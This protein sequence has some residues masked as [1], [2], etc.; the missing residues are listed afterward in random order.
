MLRMAFLT[1]ELLACFLLQFPSVLG[2]QCQKLSIYYNLWG[3]FFKKTVGF[4]HM[5]TRKNLFTLRETIFCLKECR[6][7]ST[8]EVL[9]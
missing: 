5:N 9:R 7:Q 4:S 8:Q 6:L 3:S 1:H 2:K